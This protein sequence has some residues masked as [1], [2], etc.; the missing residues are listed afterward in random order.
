MSF[1]SLEKKL[2]INLKKFESFNWFEK[3]HGDRWPKLFFNLSQF[4]CHLE[5]NSIFSSLI[6]L[7]HCYSIFIIYFWLVRFT[8]ILF[9][10][11]YIFLSLIYFQLLFPYMCSYKKNYHLY[12]VFTCIFNSGIVVFSLPKFISYYTV[13]KNKKLFKKRA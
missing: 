2:L 1:P 6:F 8:T 11:S 5:N 9:V 3:T 13:Y 4:Y 12:V 7:L 10:F